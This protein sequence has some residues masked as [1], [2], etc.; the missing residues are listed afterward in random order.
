MVM[1]LFSDLGCNHRQNFFTVSH[2]SLSLKLESELD[3]YY[4]KNVNVRVA[5]RV[6]KEQLQT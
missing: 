1:F 6:A 2:K 3:S 5:S 4:H